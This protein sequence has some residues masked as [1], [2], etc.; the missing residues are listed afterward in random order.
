[1]QLG[2]DD[3]W[4][5]WARPLARSARRVRAHARGMRAVFAGPA[6]HG[7]PAVWYGF[8]RIPEAHDVAA[9]GIVKLQHLASRFPNQSRRFNVLYL[10]SSRL[11]DAPEAVAWWAKRNGARLVVN[12][13]GVAYSAWHGPGWERVNAPMAALLAAAD[14][15]FYQSEFCRVSADRF[16]GRAAGPAEILHNAVDVVHFQPLARSTD[17]RGL[18]LLLA[19]SQD[20]WYRVE[21]AVRAVAS[22]T[23]RGI[24]AELVVTGRLRWSPDTRACRTQADELV[25]SLGVANRV[26]WTGVYSQAQ[27]PAL[28]QRADVLLHT[29]YN[30]PCPTVVIEALACGVPVVYSASGGVPELVG[31]DAGVGV[32]AHLDWERDVPPD[33]EALADGVEKVRR[34]LAQYSEAARQ[35]ALD[36]FDA[37]QWVA[38]HADVFEGLVE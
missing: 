2:F 1:M 8:D 3:A 16:A 23:R 15:V 11:P 29:K 18:V 6:P 22:L 25:G 17:Q 31:P 10:V 7:R 19:G 34:H 36:R 32:P 37:R 13:N 33:P 21:S 5:G 12:Q 14:H 4:V 38:R 35:R 20:Q 9:G 26:T 27:A 24:D 28:F 30:D